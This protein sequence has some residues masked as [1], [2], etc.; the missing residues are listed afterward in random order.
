[1]TCYDC[2][3]KGDHSEAI[4]VCHHCSVG[5]CAAHGT[6]VADPILVNVPLNR[7]VAVPKK[8]REFLCRTCLE[9]LRQRHAMEM[10][11]VLTHEHESCG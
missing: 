1:M 2:S 6:L 11:Q 4:G 7:L 5:L 8:A 10:E 9:A 3:L